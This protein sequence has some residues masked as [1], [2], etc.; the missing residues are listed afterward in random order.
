MT[1]AQRAALVKEYKNLYRNLK[2]S[3]N[4]QFKQ[5]IIN[6]SKFFRL[7]EMPEKINKTELNKLKKKKLEWDYYMGRDLTGE[8]AKS[9]GP[10]VTRAGGQNIREQHNRIQRAVREA[11]EWTRERAEEEAKRQRIRDAVLDDINEGNDDWE[12][13]KAEGFDWDDIP[14]ITTNDKLGLIDICNAAIQEAYDHISD[15]DNKAKWTRIKENGELCLGWL[16]DAGATTDMQEWY[17]FNL[18]VSGTYE[19]VS[20]DLEEMIYD[21]DQVQYEEYNDK[22]LKVM[23]K[24]PK[25]LTSAERKRLDAIREKLGMT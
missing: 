18:Q 11:E 5:G 2:R 8:E 7:P 22:I 23:S 15:G 25:K 20:Q 6:I 21:S 9:L 12:K 17:L 10:D 13:A 1:K 4:R 24:Q 16:T 14:D 3:I 19:E